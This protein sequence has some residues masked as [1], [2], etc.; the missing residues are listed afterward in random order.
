MPAARRGVLSWQDYIHRQ[1]DTRK[2]PAFVSYS[3]TNFTGRGA[4]E[5]CFFCQ[6]SFKPLAF[7]VRCC[8]SV[9]QK[10]LK[11]HRWRWWALAE[12]LE[13]LDASRMFT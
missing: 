9:G 1:S 13:S 2:P 5:E 4:A 12:C 10:V 11:S 8:R 6:K 7:C 3:W